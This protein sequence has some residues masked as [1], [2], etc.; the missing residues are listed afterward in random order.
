MYPRSES[1]S[2]SFDSTMLYGV[3]D[4]ISVPLKNLVIIVG[5]KEQN[6]HHDKESADTCYS[7][8]IINCSPIAIG[9]AK[10][11][12]FLYIPGKRIADVQISRKT[13]L[14]CA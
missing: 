11:S 10:P 8:L 6:W 5:N 3:L 13:E 9:K 1:M 7:E 14:I 4:E 12:T 2:E